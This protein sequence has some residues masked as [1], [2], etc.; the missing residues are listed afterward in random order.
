VSFVP[1]DPKL[2]MNKKLILILCEPRTGSNLL[3]EAMESYSDLQ[4]INEFYLSPNIGLYVRKD[5]IPDDLP[6]KDLL[7]QKQQ[8]SLFG[9][10]NIDT[11]NHFDML[12]GIYKS[13]IKS[14]LE[15]Y[16]V[17]EKTLV[18][19]IMKAHF[20]ELKLDTLLNLPFVEVIL[21]E[22]LNKLEEYVS[23]RKAIELDQWYNTDTSNIK[24]TV[25]IDKFLEKRDQSLA[26]YQKIRQ[27]LKSINRSCL[28]LNYEE[29]LLDFNQDEFCKMF[30][31]WLQSC[32]IALT[33]TNH[34]MKFFKKQNTAPIEQSILNYDEIKHLVNKTI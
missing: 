4:C 14:L 22:R 1:Q 3:C 28:E 34:R 13:P 19:K 10:L 21:L 30:D 26:W 8:D 24:I 15:L 18:V 25:D 29:H 31:I 23:H 2:Q 6:H 20:E 9:V 5:H 12:V 11:G 32:N 33:K 7:T 27:H 17:T 16:N